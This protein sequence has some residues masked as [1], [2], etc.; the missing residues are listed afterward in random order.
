VGGPE[1]ERLRADLAAADLDRRH[2]V[3]DVEV[4]DVL[5]L[6]ARHGLEVQS[7]GRPA[8]ADPV[9]FACG[10]AAGKLSATRIKD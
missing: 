1:E 10:A 3:V 5:D 9:L 7:M 6:F 2:E 8:A 4:P